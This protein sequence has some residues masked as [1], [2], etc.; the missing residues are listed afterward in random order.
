MSIN[1]VVVMRG[2]LYM[3]VTNDAY[4]LPEA[5]ADSPHE[6]A[7]MLG[8]TA[9]CV[10]SSITHQRAGWLKVEVGDERLDRK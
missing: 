2:Y 4:E 5:V 3:K 6:L 9:N 10:S 7:K 8:T 1:E